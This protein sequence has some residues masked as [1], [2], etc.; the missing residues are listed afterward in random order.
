ME[1]QP[2]NIDELEKE[3][4]SEKP[5]A[6]W[7]VI[8]EALCDFAEK[9]P[10]DRQKVIAILH[11]NQFRA[12]DKMIADAAGTENARL[13]KLLYVA[14]LGLSVK[15]FQF[16]LQLSDYLLKMRLIGGPLAET[17]SEAMSVAL[18][19]YDRCR[20]KWMS[21]SRTAEDALKK[22]GSSGQL[23]TTAA[24]TWLEKQK[25]QSLDKQMDVFLRALEAGKVLYRFDTEGSPVSYTELFTELSKLSGGAFTPEKMEE[26]EDSD[27]GF[28]PFK[29]F[30]NER[31]YVWEIPKRDDWYNLGVVNRLADRALED[32]GIPKRFIAC[33][34]TDQDARY[35]FANP[36]SLQPVILELALPFEMSP[37]HSEI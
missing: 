9:S 20:V 32:A 13:V 15:Q 25:K 37:K 17:Y 6:S 2:K 5:S 35:I 8:A 31:R 4:Y 33:E 11:K 14:A 19:P 30:V 12:I 21:A 7:K 18:D 10:E 36:Q 23:N 3:L 16:S 24:L 28:Q 1:K 34:S 29:F 22:L 27:P 26:D